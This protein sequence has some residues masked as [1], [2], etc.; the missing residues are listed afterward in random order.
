MK[1]ICITA[2]TLAA[3]VLASPLVAA[4]PR[5]EL[6]ERQFVNKSTILPDL[7]REI[8]SQTGAIG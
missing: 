6:E 3:G 4:G 7:L 1:S 8:K 5:L 2:L